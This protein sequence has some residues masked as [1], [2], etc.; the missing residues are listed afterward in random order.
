LLPLN[1]SGGG[2]LAVNVAANV[3]A[4]ARVVSSTAPIDDPLIFERVE[5]PVKI[6]CASS[7]DIIVGPGGLGSVVKTAVC[8]RRIS[9]TA[10]QAC[11]SSTSIRLRYEDIPVVINTTRYV[12]RATA[13]EPVRYSGIYIGSPA[14]DANR[15]SGRRVSSIR[16]DSCSLRAHKGK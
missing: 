13:R 6:W 2:V 8:A 5:V 7:I 10:H 15:L 3:E 12:M 9:P 14:H 11:V 1:N 4:A 16:S